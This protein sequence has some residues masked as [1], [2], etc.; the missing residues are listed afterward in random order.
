MTEEDGK[1]VTLKFAIDM[2]KVGATIAAENGATDHQLMAIF[3]WKSIAEAQRYTKKARQ[4]R[5]AGSGMHL[6]RRRKEKQK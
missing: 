6:L 1:L 5:L 2:R 3:G 4:E